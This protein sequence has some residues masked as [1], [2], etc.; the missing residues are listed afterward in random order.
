MTPTPQ[1]HKGGTGERE[2]R[3]TTDGVKRE[4]KGGGGQ[5]AVLRNFN[6]TDGRKKKKK[7]WGRTNTP[8]SERKVCPSYLG[9]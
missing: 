1:S 6:G 2:L 4:E 5:T 9:L 8:T 7:K 3:K